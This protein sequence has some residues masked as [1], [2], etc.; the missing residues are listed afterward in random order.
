MA[1]FVLPF[2]LIPLVGSPAVLAGLAIV[3]SVVGGWL[4]LRDRSLRPSGRLLGAASGAAVAVIVILAALAGS[5]FR[6]PTVHLIEGGGGEIFAAT[7]DEIASVEAGRI[8]RWLQLWVSGTSMTTITA[9]TKLMPLLP[10]MLRPDAER[11]LVI[12]FGMGT[13]FRTALNAGIRTDAVELVPSVP[14]MFSWFYPDAEKVLADPRGRVI[15]ADGRNHVELTGDTYDF[16]VVDPPPPIESSGV[17]VISTLEFYQAA[18]SR[19]T[20]DGVLM[21][22]VPMGQTLDE[23]L[24]HVRTFLAVFPNVRVI[25]GPGGAGF[26]LLGSEGSV[27]LEPT[28]MRAALERPGVLDDVNEAPDSENRTVGQWVATI[29][30]LTW[31]SGDQLRAAVGDGPLITDDRP[32]PEYFILRRLADPDVRQLT[33]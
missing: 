29:N 7:E 23:F 26:Y 1:A 28:P 12:A 10:L 2:V 31:A 13:S 8:G 33:L 3:N 21:Q 17:S 18:K 22:W 20:S 27:D 19:L 30:E 14:K 25:A 24:A 15:I 11:G 6:N 32:L 5:A 4:L 9:D 16:V